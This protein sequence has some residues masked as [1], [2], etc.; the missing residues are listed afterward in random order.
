VKGGGFFTEVEPD[1]ML[2]E[3]HR[4]A[5]DNPI[6]RMSMIVREGGRLDYGDWGDCRIIARRDIDSAAVTAADQVLGG[7]IINSIAAAGV[8]AAYAAV[9]DGRP[10]RGV[11]AP[12][13]VRSRA[14]AARQGQP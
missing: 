9:V 8:L 2:T 3:V 6:V 4:Q 10:T 14:F 7:E 12:W 1:V 5:A 11:D 13:P